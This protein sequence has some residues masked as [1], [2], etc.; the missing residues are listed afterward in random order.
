MI[1]VFVQDV[2]G[3]TATRAGMLLMPAGLLLV[4]VLPIT[5]RLSDKAPGHIMVAIGLAFF[6]AG[7]AAMSTGDAHVSFWTFAGFA[8][9]S[10]FGL[11]FILPSLSAAA[12]KALKPDELARGSGNMNFIRQLGGA[13]GTNL[14]VVLLQMRHSSHSEEMMRSQT[15]SNGATRELM[16]QLDE[17][18]SS[19][20]L[21]E[22]GTTAI[23]NNYVM[24][25]IDA[26]ALAF[27][28]QDCFLALAVVF[29]IAIVPAFVLGKFGDK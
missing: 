25:M 8:A 18:L 14:I 6:A 2:Q 22:E 24:Q 16:L 26:Q 1:P 28:F 19:A 21:G 3:Y 11:A 23:A 15:P 13:S 4:A 27:A 12:F 5:G 20:G 7:V 17:R 29:T 10:R 9:L